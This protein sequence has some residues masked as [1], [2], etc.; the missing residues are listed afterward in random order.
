SISPVFANHPFNQRHSMRSL[1][2]RLRRTR[3]SAHPSADPVRAVTRKDAP[4]NRP[5]FKA[6]ALPTPPQVGGGLPLAPRFPKKK[7]R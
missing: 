4:L 3:G 2:H 7:S 5:V 1:L 6:P